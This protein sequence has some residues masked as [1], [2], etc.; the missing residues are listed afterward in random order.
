MKDRLWKKVV[1]FD[2]Q[3]IGPDRVRFSEELEG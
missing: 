2:A 1:V 3:F